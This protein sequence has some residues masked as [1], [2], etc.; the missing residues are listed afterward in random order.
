LISTTLGNENGARNT[1]LIDY[2]YEAD[3]V[4]HFTKANPFTLYEL[5][6]NGEVKG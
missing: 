4:L 6:V 3:V 1:I 2:Y 5:K